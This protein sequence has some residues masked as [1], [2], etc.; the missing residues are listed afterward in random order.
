MSWNGN[1]PNTKPPSIPTSPPP[2]RPTLSASVTN[3]E[4]AKKQPDAMDYLVTC[5]LIG[6][7]FGGGE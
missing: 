1:P 2:P 3:D 7:F 6:S 4:P 5:L